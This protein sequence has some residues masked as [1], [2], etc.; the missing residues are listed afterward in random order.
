MSAARI[1]LACK[2]LMPE[3]V[4]CQS[5]CISAYVQADL[6]EDDITYVS[7]PRE[8]WPEEHQWRFENGRTPYVRLRKAMYG[9]PKAG[10]LWADKLAGVLKEDGFTEVEGWPSMYA[11]TLVG[12]PP[13]SLTYM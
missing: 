1:L 5:D 10:D 3:L 13:S 11:K 4:L 2:M 12:S 9:H 6:P 7:L 8:W